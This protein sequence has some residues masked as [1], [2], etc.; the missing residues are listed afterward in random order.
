MGEVFKAWDPVLERHVALKVL[1]R[2]DPV[3]VERMLREARAQARIDHPNVGEVYEVGETEDGRHFISMQL[4]E[5]EP[6]DQAA[7]ELSVDER[8]RLMVDVVNA[9]RA[10]HSV[11]LIH[12]DL[13]PSNILVEGDPQSGLRPYVLDFGIARENDGQALTITGDLVGT[14]AY[15]SPEQARGEIRT[16]DRRSD[17]YSL[18]VILYELLGGRS[19]YAEATGAQVLVAVLQED[20]T[21]LRRFAPYV[22]RDLETIAATCLRKNRD[23]RYPSARE[24]GEDLRRYLNGEP[25][26]A[27]RA[28][29]AMRA[30]SWVRRHR[31]ATALGLVVLI[32]APAGALK[33]AFD[34]RTERRLALAAGLEAEELMDFML[35]D[36]YQRL[37]PLGRT[38]LLE[39]VTHRALAH[40]NRFA[41]A[42]QTIAGRHR[43][44][45]AYRNLGQVLE[46]QGSP[47]E[48]LASFRRAHELM[49][50]IAG[51]N[52]N[53]ARWRRELTILESALAEVLLERGDAERSREACEAALSTAR[54]LVERF[55]DGSGNLAEL[56][57][58]TANMVWLHHQDGRLGSA[59]EV[60]E[61]AM[62]IASTG[63]AAD[64]A[65][66]EWIYRLSV[67]HGYRGMVEEDRHRYAAALESYRL[68]SERAGELIRREPDNARWVFVAELNQ[69]R[70]GHVLESM[71]DLSGAE[72]E[73]REALI[74]ARRLVTRDAANVRWRRELGV[75]LSSQG[76]ILRLLGRASEAVELLDES[77][78][79]SRGLATLDPINDSLAND[80]AWDLVQTGAVRSDLGDQ[81]SAAELWEE[82]LV[83]IAPV[84]ERSG[85]AWYRDTQV[86]AL[87]R[88]GRVEEA[89]PLVKQ[90]RSSGWDDAEFLELARAYGLLD[91]G[92]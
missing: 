8:V 49:F 78:A 64:V 2:D 86:S 51:E 83:V 26:A 45:L 20:P 57:Q 41:A 81:E 56:W 7:V 21:P 70:I 11:G 3:A 35:E 23:R 54:F 36:L 90:L 55:G 46:S 1:R 61:D 14:P 30:H 32:G 33:Y 31:L 87:L 76:N 60:L 50:D 5:G 18:G 47:D 10:A 79:I 84:A 4:V 72:Q 22:P 39:D 82:A 66:N 74:L 91:D 24:L 62:G 37:L 65:D 68:A 71:G 92:G 25:I 59:L 73:Y 6:L 16:L 85:I 88:L 52:P 38:D 44:A 69:S 58:A 28:S 80:L 19:P 42:D 12:R 53:E 63:A 13:K 15:M 29:W 75:V 48:A 34:L 9:V 17:I 77:L 89:R 43:R 40:H 27:R 67:T